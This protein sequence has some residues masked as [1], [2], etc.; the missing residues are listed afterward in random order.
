MLRVVTGSEMRS[1]EKKA[2]ET[3][4]LSSLVVMENAG[5]RIVEVLKGEFAPLEAKRVH[6]LAGM[7]NNGGDG[8][9]VARQLMALGVRVKVLLV[10]DP[11]RA[12]PE[13]AANLA[14]LH[15]M[16]ADLTSLDFKQLHRLKL[17]L[18]FADLIIDALLGT[19]FSGQLDDDWTSLIQIVNEIQCPVVAI[20]CPTGVNSATGEV[21]TAAIRADLTINLGLLKLGCLLYPGRA[22]AG[23][24][25]V[26]DLGFPLNAVDIA[27]ELVGSAALGWLPERKPWSH[28][29]DHGH[30]LVVAGSVGF[31]GA[32]NLC[33][34]A[35]LRGGGGMVT[36]A[37]PEI[38][39]NRFPPDELMVVPLPEA[40]GGT[41]G[42]GSLEKL[43]GLLA[44]KDVLAIGP[45]LGSSRQV[46]KVVQTLL[47][48]WDGPA[49]IDAD[50]LGALS[51]EFLSNVPAA[52]RRRWVIT[53]HPGEMARLMGS[54]AAN[55]NASR[56]T[57][58]TTFARQWG[59]VVVLKG[60]PTIT[61][62]GERV[63]INSTGNHGLATAGTGDILTGLTAA[64]L[65]QGLDALRAGAL[66]AYVHG[67]AGD[68]AAEKGARGLKAGDCLGFIQEILK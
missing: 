55:I 56:V 48:L 60:A 49:V 27:R 52:K 8:L 23:R 30:T 32:A 31:A 11:K 67:L 47:S 35:V 51:M 59:L 19:G 54:D 57:A 28:K 68:L 38:I 2:F 24:N 10:G 25:M 26:V 53:P 42:E 62:D 41:L 9:V 6:I 29:G 65:G 1:L 63:Y 45:G 16:G 64:L 22:Y 33:A 36:V 34:Q 12:T 39:Y 58:A 4:G 17:S 66:A 61:S 7:G 40:E 14:I 46:V 21:A 15:K 18:G 50:G 3:L 13:N 5:S 20:D 43:Q 37:V 44:G